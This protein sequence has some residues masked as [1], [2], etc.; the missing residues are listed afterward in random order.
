VLAL[1][2]A[3]L[4]GPV[5]DSMSMGAVVSLVWVPA[6]AEAVVVDAGGMV[7]WG[8]GCGRHWG[9]VNRLGSMCHHPDG[10]GHCSG[11]LSM[12]FV[13]VC[14]CDMVTLRG[15]LLRVTG[16]NDAGWGVFSVWV[17]VSLVL[18]MVQMLG[19]MWSIICTFFARVGLS[20]SGG[21]V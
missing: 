13:V 7:V 12:M 11:V 16:V 6:E 15:R 4:V 21:L 19:L 20:S 9:P 8:E 1:V 18:G 14:S 10:G 3:G 17:A 5:W 2:V